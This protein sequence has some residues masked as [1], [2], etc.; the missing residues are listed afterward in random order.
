MYLEKVV[1]IVKYVFSAQGKWIISFVN[2]HKC[3]ALLNVNVNV[4]DV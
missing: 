2:L 3:E 1:N 4:D